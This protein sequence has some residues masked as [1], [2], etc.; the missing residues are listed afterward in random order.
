MWNIQVHSL[1]VLTILQTNHKG[2]EEQVVFF[3]S[4]ICSV[5]YEAD[6]FSIYK[7]GCL[8]CLSSSINALPSSFRMSTVICWIL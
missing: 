5:I 8:S 7:P 4:Y 2:T 3:T 6:D 1:M